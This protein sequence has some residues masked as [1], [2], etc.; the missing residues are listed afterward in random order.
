M[1]KKRK[2]KMYNKCVNEG[3]MERGFQFKTRVKQ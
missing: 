1:N 3:S 2:A